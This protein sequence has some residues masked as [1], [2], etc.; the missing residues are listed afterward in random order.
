MIFYLIHLLILEFFIFVL[1][2][3]KRKL[4]WFIFLD[5]FLIMALRGPR[6]GTDMANYE[7]YF[8][9]F[10]NLSYF[11]ILSGQ[12]YGLELGYSLLNKTISLFSHDFRALIITTSLLEMIGVVYFC[13]ENSSDI[14]W[15][16]W[17]YICL[18]E[19]QYAFTRIRQGIAISFILLS[20]QFIK[21]RDFKK[22]L[23]FVLLATLF[24]RS[25]IFLLFLYPLVVIYEK[26]VNTYFEKIK[27]ILIGIPFLLLILREF[28]ATIVLQFFQNYVDKGVTLGEG[29][30]LMIV[31]IICFIF[32][33][34]TMKKV[35]QSKLYNQS[36]FIL[37]FLLMIVAQILTP[38]YS[39][40]NRLGEYT[41]VAV[42]FTLPTFISLNFD[43]RNYNIIKYSSSFMVLIFYILLLANTTSTTIPYKIF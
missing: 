10:S 1:H 28:I 35:E 19:Y 6:V 32:A 42:I 36:I 2:K 7:T 37:S 4:W 24:H 39:L 38:Y 17:I 27:L 30:T 20:I 29:N 9:Y 33:V 21:K 25:A 43:K 12:T 26:Y 41:L 8:H 18:F 16:L 11:D 15:S 14:S 13:K 22:Y 23:M 3:D 40:F 31:Y 5:L 34:V